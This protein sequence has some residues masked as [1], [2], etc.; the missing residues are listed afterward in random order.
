[1][2]FAMF[3]LRVHPQ[4]SFFRMRLGP[5]GIRTPT[6]D[7]LGTIKGRASALFHPPTVFPSYSHVRIFVHL[8][9]LQA[10]SFT[11]DLA[12]DS[13]LVLASRLL[14]LATRL[15]SLRYWDLVDALSLSSFA[16]AFV[17]SLYLL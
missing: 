13:Y 3:D 8:H 17:L 6:F 5:T 15:D 4:L 7:L 2:V 9:P 1:M 12:T 11:L 10:P 16:V 14:G